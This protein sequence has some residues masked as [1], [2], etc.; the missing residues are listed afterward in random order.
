M[1]KD[2]GTIVVGIL[3]LAAGVAVGGSMLGVF[4]F[5]VDLAGWWTIFILGPAV[6][7]IFSGGLNVGNG[8][9]L[10]VG[11]TLL[12]NA[13]GMLPEG[14][15]WKLIVPLILV[16]IGVQVIF[17][18]RFA[19]FGGG[20]GKPRR[21]RPGSASSAFCGEERVEFPGETYTGGTYSAVCGAVT[22][23]LRTAI[24]SGEITINVSVLMGGIEIKLPDNVRLDARVTPILGGA[25]VTYASSRDPL[26]PKV[27]VVGTVM[28]GGVEIK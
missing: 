6:I 17:G 23:D 14:F 7:S 28:L 2:I 1:K 11:T 12:L 10:F 20:P 8:V 19:C 21:C 13:Q 22:V 25:D 26:S 5:T 24:I 4:D 18:T 27:T 3:F 15:S 16:L 9:L